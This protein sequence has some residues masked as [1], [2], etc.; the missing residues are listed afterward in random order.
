MSKV[1]SIL[2]AVFGLLLVWVLLDSVVSFLWVGLWLSGLG[3]LWLEPLAVVAYL[4]ALIFI[5]EFVKG[6]TAE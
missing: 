3:I 1:W 2:Q 5:F 6:L 4:A